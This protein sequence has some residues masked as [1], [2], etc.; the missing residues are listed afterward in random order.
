[1]NLFATLSAAGPQGSLRSLSLGLIPFLIIEG[2]VL[3]VLFAFPGL[4][5]WLPGH[6]FGP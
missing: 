4:S 6:M 3:A 2:V 1:M 5:T